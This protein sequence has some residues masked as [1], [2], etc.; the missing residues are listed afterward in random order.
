LLAHELG[1]GGAV[2]GG[3]GAPGERAVILAVPEVEAGEGPDDFGFD[4]GVW[5]S[6]LGAHG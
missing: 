5:A 2:G 3:A 1:D 4:G 6:S